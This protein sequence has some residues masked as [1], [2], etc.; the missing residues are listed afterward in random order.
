MTQV[1]AF[2]GSLIDDSQLVLGEGP[3]YD[4]ISNRLVW[5]NILGKELHELDLETNEKRVHQ[6]PFMASVY[7]VIDDKRQLLASEDGLF[8]RERDS[9]ALELHVELESDKPNNR[10]NDGR[11]HPSGALWIGTMSKVAEKHAGAIY[12]VA[13]GVVTKLFDQI[14]IPNGIC[15]SPDGSRGYFIDTMTN[16]YMTVKLDAH[17][18]LPVGKIELFLDQSDTGSGCDGAICDAEGYI[19]NARWGGSSILRYA[20]DGSIAAQYNVPPKQPTCPVFYGKD[21]SQIA[22]TSAF[23]HMDEA[24]RAAT[25]ANG[26]TFN[27]GVTVKGIADAAY[28]L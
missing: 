25:E 10:S 21:L 14:S 7:A 17:T 6:L 19:W 1:H 13:K 16:H 22:F 26:Q 23:E 12:H 15:F 8:I 27:L 9:G 28:K 20:P 3:S 5:F 18:G 2:E 4:P 24:T 11:I